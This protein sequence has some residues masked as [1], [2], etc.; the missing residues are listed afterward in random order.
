MTEKL[1]LWGWEG[2]IGGFSARLVWVEQGL[3]VWFGLVWFGLG[4]LW[5][6]RFG[7]GHIR[8]DMTI[9]WVWL[10]WVREN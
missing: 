2:W 7:F 3:L 6:I 8:S 10:R 9:G 5:L 1:F 4:S